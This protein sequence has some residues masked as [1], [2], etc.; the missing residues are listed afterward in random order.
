MSELTVLHGRVPTR[1]ITA[2]RGS[3]EALYSD[4]DLICPGREIGLIFLNNGETTV[5]A[6]VSLGLISRARV[7][8]RTLHIELVSPKARELYGAVLYERGA[9]SACTENGLACVMCVGE[10]SYI[11]D[12]LDVVRCFTDN[13]MDLR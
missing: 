9:R 12:I 11:G 3:F 1:M 8:G 4:G 6:V 2:L 5:E 13:V 10:G 7:D